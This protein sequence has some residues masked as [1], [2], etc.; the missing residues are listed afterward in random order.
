MFYGAGMKFELNIAA[1]YATASLLPSRAV[2]ALL[3][4][5]VDLLN[6]RAGD[7]DFDPG[8]TAPDH[9]L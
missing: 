6:R 8:A 3:E 5:L 7:P 4:R 9:A 2:A 1:L